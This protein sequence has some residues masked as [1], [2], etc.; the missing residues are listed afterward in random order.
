MAQVHHG[1]WR[2]RLP[3][4]PV[5]AEL[6]A[7]A[8]K[9]IG[10]A[11]QHRAFQNLRHFRRLFTYPDGVTIEALW[12]GTLWITTITGQPAPV[13]RPVRIPRPALWVPKGFVVLPAT[14]G[15]P[16]GWGL[17]VVPAPDT[18]GPLDPANLVPGL[19]LARWTA[20]GPLGEVLLT[21]LPDA[22]YPGVGPGARTVPL[23]WHREHGPRPAQDEDG[24][25]QIGLPPSNPDWSAH[26]IAF[27][28]YRAQQPGVDAAQAATIAAEKRVVFERVN[29][30]RATAGR[31]P[32]LPPIRGY[33]DTAQA[34]ADQA[35]AAQVLGAWAASY[36]PTWR[37]EGDR[38]AR[39]GISARPAPAAGDD[40]NATVN[41]TQVQ[42][43]R[44]TAAPTP[45]GVDPVGQPI[46]DTAGGGPAITGEQAA[47]DF[48]ASG[49]AAAQLLGS[50]WDTFPGSA[51][52]L[53]VGIRDNV[54][55]AHVVRREAWIDTGNRQ[56]ISADPAIP[57][58]TWWGA[59]ALNLGDE[60]YP[61]TGTAPPVGIDP[62]D[63]ALLFSTW[64]P[65]T[66]NRRSLY[67]LD[68]YCYLRHVHSDPALPPDA[69]R[70]QPFWESRIFCRG[71]CIAIAPRNGLVWAAAIR[72]TEAGGY[73]LVALVHDPNDEP[74][75]TSQARAEGLTR[76]V[77][78]WRCD[79][80]DVEGLVAN[81][82][83]CIRGVRGEA[84]AWPWDDAEDPYAWTDGQRIDVG[85]SDGTTRDL[86]VLASQ[87]VFAPN[88]NS[89][90][91]A[92]TWGRYPEAW[93]TERGVPR[94]EQEINLFAW[95]TFG[96]GTIFDHT[97][98]P[99][100]LRLVLTD[101]GATRAWDGFPL[102]AVPQYAATGV[103]AARAPTDL[104]EAGPWIKPALEPAPSA[105]PDL[106]AV[107][108]AA[109]GLRF[110]LIAYSR[111]TVQDFDIRF[112]HHTYAVA[113]TADLATASADWAPMAVEY[114]QVAVKPGREHLGV[115]VANAGVLVL[116]CADQA[117]VSIGTVPRFLRERAIPTSNICADNP[118]YTLCWADDTTLPWFAVNAWVGGQRVLSRWHPNPDRVQINNLYLCHDDGINGD[119]QVQ[120][121]MRT[122][123]RPHFARADGAWLLAYTVQPQ[124]GNRAVVSVAG[125]CPQF[126]ASVY[127]VI[128]QSACTPRFSDLGTLAHGEHRVA[129]AGAA[130]SFANED[131]LMTLMQIPG[132]GRRLLHVGAV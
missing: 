38:L 35:A 72:R 118:A 4:G 74:A 33:A 109:T 101:S 102:E 64:N 88:G 115:V 8:R 60:T 56:W 112:N 105:W 3:D 51:S 81:P 13:I 50:A 54:A 48:E 7:R 9:A 97:P 104:P 45:I 52:A 30:L 86:L 58:L 16:I 31:P 129:G 98:R 25:W 70:V 73:Q 41:G 75:T 87:W 92:R 119:P 126:Q 71:R 10:I 11:E 32:L 65:H 120:M 36:D 53:N 82:E 21:R 84:A 130:A 125:D 34:S 39:D 77:R 14:D 124:D 20:A 17:P 91:C 47:D 44:T 59:P 117:M 22:G 43:A 1:P 111:G 123:I 80:P 26:R 24:V 114:G 110:A 122:I 55:V 61:R 99:G 69:W 29:Q 121:L 68:G 18:E 90:A 103:P 63:Q 66:V 107:D 128:F 106:V 49:Y 67:D 37:I 96:H 131:T 28:D 46:L 19:E 132:D 79:L 42:T 116:G 78:L 89:A 57:M 6:V 127:G 108:W 2:L 76:W 23:L 100:V 12:D 83:V 95:N 85:T 5:S 113:F 15:A 40:R 93:R 27:E 94:Y 62:E